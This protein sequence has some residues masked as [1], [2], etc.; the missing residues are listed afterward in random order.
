MINATIDETVECVFPFGMNLFVLKCT[1]IQRVRVWMP[2][3]HRLH[4]HLDIDFAFVSTSASH[5]PWHWHRTILTS[6]SRSSWHRLR[7]RSDMDELECVPVICP[8][9]EITATR[10]DID[11][12]VS[13]DRLR[14]HL[15][16]GFAFALTSA[17]HYHD[18]GFAFILPTI[19]LPRS[20]GQSTCP[21]CMTPSSP[22]QSLSNKICKVIRKVYEIIAILYQKTSLKPLQKPLQNLSKSLPKV[23]PTRYAK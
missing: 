1:Y 3:R 23:F 15:D 4:G 9:T 17:S 5:L 2:S 20:I 7:I 14:I 16:I 11:F 10:F 22:S 6:A 18:I 19:D 8:K 21:R 12:A 13:W